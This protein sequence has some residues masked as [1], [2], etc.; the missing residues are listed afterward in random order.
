MNIE[1]LKQRLV[2]EGCS[3]SNYSIGFRDSD[4]FCLMNENGMWR[5]FYTERGKDDAP[6][7]E[8]ASEADACEFFFKYQTEHIRHQHL[9]GF[10]RSEEKA[11]DLSETL[12]RSGVQAHQDKIPY[13]GWVDPRFRVFVIGKD[14]FKAREFLREVP[15]KD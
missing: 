7:F 4:V 5:V 12:E 6:I 2:E 15:V 11:I 1:E 9:V 3:T 13:G 14:I 8:S 10:F